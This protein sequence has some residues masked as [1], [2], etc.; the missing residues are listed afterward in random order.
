M[1]LEGE[2]KNSRLRSAQIQIVRNRLTTVKVASLD[3]A[4]LTFKPRQTGPFAVA[5]HER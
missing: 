5:A 4:K 2:R 1:T 3:L